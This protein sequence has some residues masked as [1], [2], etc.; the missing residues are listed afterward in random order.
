MIG[1]Y[2]EYVHLD[3]QPTIFL[4]RQNIHECTSLNL[5]RKLQFNQCVEGTLSKKYSVARKIENSEVRALKLT[6]QRQLLLKFS[7]FLWG[8]GSNQKATV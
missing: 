6:N 5:T 7:D 4:L 3:W 2:A 1:Q 8:L